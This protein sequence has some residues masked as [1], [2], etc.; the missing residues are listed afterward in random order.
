MDRILEQDDPRYSPDPVGPSDLLRIAAISNNQR[1]NSMN[2]NDNI[3][4]DVDAIVSTPRK[5]V[6][7]DKASAETLRGKYSCAFYHIVCI[8]VNHVLI[9]HY[10]CLTDSQ[11]NVYM[12]ILPAGVMTVV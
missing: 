10:V 6:A 1:M 4:S 11:F 5:S 3:F 7:R 9:H 2:K 12:F 8:D